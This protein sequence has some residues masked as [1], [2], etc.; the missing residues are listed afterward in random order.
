MTYLAGIIGDIDTLQVQ[1]ADSAFDLE[2]IPLNG[3][4]MCAARN[5]SH[6][7]FGSRQAPTEIAADSTFRLSVAVDNYTRAGTRFPPITVALGKSRWRPTRL[8]PKLSTN[9]NV[10]SRSS[11]IAT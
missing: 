4:P 8:P 10:P 1:F 6:V 11:R 7:V 9:S 3:I 5:E 2:T